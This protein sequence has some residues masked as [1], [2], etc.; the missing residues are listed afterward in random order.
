MT[1][2]ALHGL[3]SDRAGILSYLPPGLPMQVI[4]PDI[5]AHGANPEIGT[6]DQFR[7]ESLA[8]EIEAGLAAVWDGTPVTVIGVSMGAA[9]GLRIV[10]RGRFPIDRF[11][12]L[13]PSFDHRPL[14][15]NLTIFPVIAELLE[16]HSPKAA[17]AEFREM[18]LYD[19]VEAISPFAVKA[20]ELHITQPLARERRRRLSEVPRNAAYA[21]GELES[22]ASRHLPAVVLASPRDPVHPVTVGEAWAAGLRCR[23]L[24]SPERDRGVK[25]Y[26]AWYREQLAS[27]LT[28]AR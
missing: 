18:R 23:M 1:V 11:A 10:L 7:L 12:A 26:A 3:G 19:E 17:L 27:F 5:R 2:L 21:P 8:D 24:L 14:P 15:Q 20:L 4:A 13:R 6:T 25:P 16:R 9:I 28:G 22:L